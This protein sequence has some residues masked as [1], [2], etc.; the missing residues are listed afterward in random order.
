MN[1]ITIKIRE[2]FNELNLTEQKIASYFLENSDDIINLNIADLANRCGVSQSALTRFNKKIGFNG[3]KDLKRSLTADLLESSRGTA[4][5]LGNDYSDIMAG[6]STDELVEKICKNNQKA[7]LETQCLL[8][9]KNLE[10]A[11]NLL[12]ETDRVDFYGVGA[13]GLV[14]LD[15]Q[16]KFMRIGKICNANLDPHIQLVLASNLKK[17]D[18]AVLISNSGMTEDILDLLTIAHE[19]GAHVIAITKYGKNRLNQ[20]ADLIL[21]TCSPE[22][23]IR[24]GAT[25]SRIAQLTIIDLLFIGVAGKNVNNY[26]K[27]LNKSYKYASIKKVNS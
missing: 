13:S 18:V 15:A 8:D 10:A 24:S 17:N 11:I 16:Q 1:K 12:C 7:I 21:N 23:N 5:D 22:I 20:E 4:S 19:A 6:D 27:A 26:Q 2:V 14:A 3:L 9:R 25:S